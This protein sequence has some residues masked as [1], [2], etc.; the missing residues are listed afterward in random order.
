MQGLK[1]I[2]AA[3]AAELLFQLFQEKHWLL[4]EKPVP[5]ADPDIEQEAV[6]FILAVAE[7]GLDDWQGLSKPAREVV[8]LLLTDF[9]YKLMNSDSSFASR[10]WQ[11]PKG[12]S[13][14]KKALLII[15]AEIRQS[16]PHFSSRH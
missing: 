15:A 11:M 8:S 16:Y 12:L 4:T 2:K 10:T 7:Q 6:S 13:S 9:L 5:H 3:E 1:T 14:A